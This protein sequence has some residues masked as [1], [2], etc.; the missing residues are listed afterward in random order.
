MIG[1]ISCSLE[2]VVAFFVAEQVA[3]LTDR[4]PK[5]LVGQLGEH[6]LLPSSTRLPRKTADLRGVPLSY[7]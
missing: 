4:L 7:Q 6:P 5:L 1:S 2:E 3:H